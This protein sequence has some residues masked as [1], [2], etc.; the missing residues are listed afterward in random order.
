MIGFVILSF[1][2]SIA[3]AERRRKN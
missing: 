1:T 2:I 3:Y